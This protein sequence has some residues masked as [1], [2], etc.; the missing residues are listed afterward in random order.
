MKKRAL[1]TG[2]ANEKSLAWAIAKQLHEQGYELAFCYGAERLEGRV[3]KLAEPLKAPIIEKCDVT[4]DA[5]LDILFS[6]ISKVWP[7]GFDVLVHSIA[8]A[9]MDDLRGRFTDVSRKGFSTALEISAFSLMSLA[10]RAES[11]LEKKQGSIIA[12]TYHGSQKV[13]PGYGIMGVAKA[14]LESS[15]RYLA[16]DLGP[17]KI[18]VNAISAGAVR[19]LSSAAIPKF[20]E[21]LDFAADKAPLKENISPEDVARL[22][23]FL[24]GPGGKHI[25]GGCHYVD[26]GINIMA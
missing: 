22:T 8:F 13:V 17:K 25:T 19:T 20:R 2:V 18:R 26:S 11:L 24:V 1:I 14:A 7:D 21:K 12:L 15:V 23:A 3:R 6:K 4:D 10:N 9:E 16:Y 5:S